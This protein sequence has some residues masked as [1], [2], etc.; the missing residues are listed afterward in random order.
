MTKKSWIALSAGLAFTAVLLLSFGQQVG[1]YASFAEVKDG[2]Q[3]TVVGDS[4]LAQ[5]Y[6][7]QENV[8]RF[9]LRDEK[10]TVRRVRYPAPKPANFD[11]AEKVVVSGTMREGAFHADDILVKCPSKYKEQG[12]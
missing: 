11:R 1:G 6:S 12:L 9:R 10:G 2:Q 5:T 3:A 4:V 8:F 7:R